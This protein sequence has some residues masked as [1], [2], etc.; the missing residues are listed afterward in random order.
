VT[1]TELE[2]I[3]QI[4][5][6]VVSAEP[7]RRMGRPTTTDRINELRG[8]VD[9]IRGDLGDVKAGLGRVLQAVSDLT[10]QGMPIPVEREH[11]VPYAATDQGR[12]E[13]DAARVA[14]GKPE[15]SGVKVVRDEWDNSLARYEENIYTGPVKTRRDDA[16]GTTHQYRD[17]KP[18]A[19][20][21]QDPLTE[22]AAPHKRPGFAHR[23]LNDPVIEKLG[24]RNW[25]FV[26][27]SEGKDVR[28][29]GM[30]LARMPQ[31]MKEARDRHYEELNNS[32][33]RDAQEK[34]NE[35]QEQ[36]LRQAAVEGEDV[37]GASA[38]RPGEVLRRQGGNSE[39][40]IGLQTTRG[41]PR[42]APQQI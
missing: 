14:A 9:E 2:E 41:L 17:V 39:A 23:F 1:D 29:G 16:T 13:A 4:E 12:A 18:N 21:V 28:N 25:E 42:V 19:W 10:I 22:I 24:M 6:G 32:R 31:E 8:D 3:E 5:A 15:P 38:L 36:L 34:A 11:L 30:R 20:T 35:Q 40:F 27:D 26:K 7:R 33:A 37:R